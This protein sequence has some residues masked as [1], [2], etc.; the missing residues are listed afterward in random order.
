MQARVLLHQSPVAEVF[1]QVWK[2]GCLTRVERE[3]L[4][5]ALLQTALSAED[6]AAI[7]RLIHAVRRGWL[8]I[9]D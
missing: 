6:T 8:K 4:K 1:G 2:T 3:W 5:N 9:V 7:D